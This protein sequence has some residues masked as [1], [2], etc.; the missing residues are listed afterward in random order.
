MMYLMGHRRSCRPQ[1]TRICGTRNAL[2]TVLVSS[3]SAPN[4]Q[5]HPQNG[6][7]PQNK[8]PTATDDHRMKISGDVRKYSQLKPVIS[9][10]ENVEHVDD[11]E[12]RVGVPSEPYEREQQ[13]AAAHPRV[14][15]RPANELV[16]KEEDRSQ[17]GDGNAGDRDGSCAAPPHLLPQRLF[18][19]RERLGSVDGAASPVCA[20][21]AWVS[22]AGGARCSLRM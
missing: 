13:K 22:A 17:N 11:G 3:W 9:E 10:L 15:A 16:L 5:S 14:E 4:G 7:R 18:L 6:P 20:V 19:H 8:R 12:L 2:A 21:F 1:G